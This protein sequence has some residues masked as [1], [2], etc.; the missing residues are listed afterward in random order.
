MQQTTRQP[1]KAQKLQNADSSHSSCRREYPAGQVSLRLPVSGFSDETT[2]CPGD[3][4]KRFQRLVASARAIERAT[5][6]EAAWMIEAEVEPQVLTQAADLVLLETVK[7]PEIAEM[8]V[9]R[10]ADLGC[11]DEATRVANMIRRVAAAA[12]QVGLANLI[13][14]FVPA[15]G[16]AGAG[17]IESDGPRPRETIRPA[18]SD[19]FSDSSAPGRADHSFETMLVVHIRILPSAGIAVGVETITIFSAR[20][21]LARNRLSW[22]TSR[23]IFSARCTTG[24]KTEGK[25][26]KNHGSKEFT[27][28]GG[29]GGRGAGRVRNGGQSQGRPGGGFSNR[30]HPGRPDSVGGLRQARSRGD[31]RG[32]ETT[33]RLGGFD[34]LPRP[35]RT[36]AGGTAAERFFEKF[37]L[38]FSISAQ[39]TAANSTGPQLPP[40]FV[41]I[42]LLEAG[43]RANVS[44]VTSEPRLA[45]A[46]T[47][48]HSKKHCLPGSRPMPTQTLDTR[49]FQK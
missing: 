36:V 26:T 6:W 43:R 4:L 17:R 29:R 40:A 47:S 18:L 37:G 30:N 44:P 49:G 16:F 21:M 42:N 8:L 14:K 7:K 31:G 41:A 11:P 22:M 39:S 35:L 13:Q 25:D 15:N 9:R 10:L 19:F 32:A 24:A 28:D 2:P 27:N 33:D 12:L 1:A 20:R 5:P 48:S 46:A 3:A 34:P 38:I 45:P 23:K